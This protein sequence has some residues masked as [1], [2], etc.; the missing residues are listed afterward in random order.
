MPLCVDAQFLE[1][2]CCSHEQRLERRRKFDLPTH[3]IISLCS[4][5]LNSY[6]ERKNP[7][8]AIKAFKRAF[9]PAIAGLSR[10]DI[11]LVI[12]TFAPAHPHADWE[13]LKLVAALDPRIHIVEANLSRT[14]LSA[15]YGCC[16]VLLSFHRAEGFGRVLAEALQLGLDV[17]ATDWSGNTDFC[18]GPLAHPVPF[19]LVPVPPGA[20]PHWPG[21][22]WAEPD[23]STAAQ[24][25]KQVVGRRLLLGP[26]APELVENYRERFSADRCGILYRTRLEELGLVSG[27][28]EQLGAGPDSNLLPPN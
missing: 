12:K 6:S 8:A 15:L 11:A 5:D 9:P 17:I 26:P 20:Y 2:T 4:F 28:K 27:P 16:D 23:P 3:S 1:L 19:N 21:Q 22:V 13:Q 25:L 10:S 7:W 18:N 14:E 24:I